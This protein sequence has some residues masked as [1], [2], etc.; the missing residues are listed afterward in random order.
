MRWTVWVRF[1]EN[2]IG[3]GEWW[4]DCCFTLA[5][6]SVEQQLW[7]ERG[8]FLLYLFSSMVR[9]KEVSSRLFWALAIET[10]VWKRS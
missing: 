1:V 4:W 10:T 6:S 9:K 5:N 3:Q 7:K 8:I 2:R